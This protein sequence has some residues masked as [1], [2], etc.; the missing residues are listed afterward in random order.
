MSARLGEPSDLDDLLLYKLSRL[1]TE[2]IQLGR[3][4]HRL[5]AP[6]PG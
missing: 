3:A 5:L 1:V 2:R 4:L 6:L